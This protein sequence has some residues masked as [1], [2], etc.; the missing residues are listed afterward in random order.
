MSDEYEQANDGFNQPSDNLPEVIRENSILSN[1]FTEAWKD[2]AFAPR[3][4][5][6]K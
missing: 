3:E 1:V 5:L 2:G 4:P 6:P